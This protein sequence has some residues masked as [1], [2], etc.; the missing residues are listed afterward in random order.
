MNG[1]VVFLIVWWLVFFMVLPIGV[2]SQ[3]ESGDVVAGTEPGA[4]TVPNLKKK[5]WWATVGTSVVWL[6]YFVITE[7]GAIEPFLPRSGGY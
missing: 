4:P 2:T 7:T 1:I 3:D 6:I 5:A